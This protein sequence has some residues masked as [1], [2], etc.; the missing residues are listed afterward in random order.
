VRDEAASVS[1]DDAYGDPDVLMRPID[2]IDKNRADLGV[3]RCLRAQGN[4][5]EQ[6]TKAAFHD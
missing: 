1:I 4:G 2:A 3:G 5:G 6:K